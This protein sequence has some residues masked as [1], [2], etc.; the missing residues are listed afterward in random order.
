MVQTKP[1]GSWTSPITSESLGKES[2]LR[3]DFNAIVDPHTNTVYWTSS[4]GEEGGRVQIFARKVDGSSETKAILPAGYNCRTQAHEYGGSAFTVHKNILFFSNF[5]DKRLYKI[6]VSNPEAVI[7]IVP[8]NPFHRY[9]DLAIDEDQRFIICVREEHF[10]NETPKDVINKLVAIDLQKHNL[11]EVVKVVAEGAD[12]YIS[13]RLNPDSSKLA[14]ISWNHPNMPWDF[15]KLHIATVTYNNAA[16]VTDDHCVVG[17]KTDESIMQPRYASDGTLYVISDRSGFW[18]IYKYHNEDIQLVLP[19]ALEQ[20]FGGPTWTFGQSD[21]RPFQSDPTKLL[22]MNKSSIAV[23]DVSAKTLTSLP[24][25]FKGAT[26]LSTAF[27]HGEEYATF[28][29]ISTDRPA[30]VVSYSIADKKVACQLQQSVVE[31]LPEAY[32]SVAQ[33][34]RFPTKEGFSYCYYFAPKNPEFQGDGLPPLKVLS[35]GGPTGSCNGSYDRKY[36]YWTSRGFAIAD[37]NYGGSTGYGRE[38][39]NRLQKNWGVVDVNDCCDAALYLAEQGYVDRE[40]LTIMGQSAGGYTTL[41]SLTFRPE[42]FKAGCSLFG[43]SDITLIAQES[44]KFELRYVDNLI[45]QYPKDI[46]LFRERSPIHFCDKIVCPVILF[47]GLDDK[48]VPP[49]QAQVMVKAL[50]ENKIPN[51]YVTYEG[52]GHGFRKP[53]NIIRTLELELWFYGKIFGFPVEGIEGVEIANYEL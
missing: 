52:E 17:D 27:V 13:P 36:L 14:Y 44:H 18:N 2:S 49:S 11:D 32:I 51:A 16:Q 29:G 7:P 22:C 25:S 30:V 19:E 8:D 6:D 9:A 5:A 28:A 50:N 20:E 1:F 43:I 42:V 34:I 24:S 23:L 37:V 46:E 39:R 4:A 48:V 10:E 33:E 35:H 53:E 21:Y 40:K 38:Y 41:A 15:T 3:H 45:G 26:Q 47:Q 12:F 31:P